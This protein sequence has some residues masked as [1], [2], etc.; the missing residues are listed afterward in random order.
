MTPCGIDGCEHRRHLVLESAGRRSGYT[1]HLQKMH[2]GYI[3]NQAKKQPELVERPKQLDLKDGS[4]MPVPEEFD[5][6][7]G[8]Y[9]RMCAYHIP[10]TIFCSLFRQVKFNEQSPSDA[11]KMVPYWKDFLSTLP[12]HWFIESDWVKRLTLVIMLSVQMTPY[13]EAIKS[14]KMQKEQ[15]S[16]ASLGASENKGT[17]K[18][19]PPTVLPG[20]NAH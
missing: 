14:W 9:A 5:E 2:P 16:E 11:L 18:P 1:R 19:P 17:E 4:T 20:A 3:W 15:E 6:R 7:L 8:E 13:I 12:Q 10:H